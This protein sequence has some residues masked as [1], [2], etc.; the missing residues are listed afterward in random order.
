MCVKLVTVVKWWI[1]TGAN[2]RIVEEISQNLKIIKKNKKRAEREIRQKKATYW[3]EIQTLQRT[4]I[5]RTVIERGNEHRQGL[6]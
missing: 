1:N 3:K 2:R 4:S 5:V 6:Y